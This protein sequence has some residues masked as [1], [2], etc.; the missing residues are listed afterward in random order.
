MGDLIMPTRR[1]L[2]IGAVFSLI[3][4]PAIVRAASIMAVKPFGLLEAL[5]VETGELSLDAYL[6]QYRAFQKGFLSGYRKVSDPVEARN[7]D[8]GSFASKWT[9]MEIEKSAAMNHRNVWIA[10][11]RSPEEA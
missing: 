10:P 3:A 5:G 11:W 7:F 2:I 9:G 8:V 4:A 1:G 6:A